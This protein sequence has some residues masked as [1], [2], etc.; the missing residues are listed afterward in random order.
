MLTRF[1][2]PSDAQTRESIKE[3]Q[4]LDIGTIILTLLQSTL[5]RKIGKGPRNSIYAGDVRTEVA[6]GVSEG[7]EEDDGGGSFIDDLNGSKQSDGKNCDCHL[8][9][10]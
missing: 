2:T 4:W 5:F 9:G 7:K 6:Y 3:M 10:K 1:Y 8:E